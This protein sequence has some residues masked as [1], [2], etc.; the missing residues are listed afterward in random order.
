MTHLKWPVTHPAIANN[1]EHF[2]GILPGDEDA[3]QL[4]HRA[5]AWGPHIRAPI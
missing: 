4:L 3:V 1:S 5:A 2:K